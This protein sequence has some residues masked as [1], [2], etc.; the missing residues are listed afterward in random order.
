MILSIR[1]KLANTVRLVRTYRY[2]ERQRKSQCKILDGLGTYDSTLHEAY[3]K[4][5]GLEQKRKSTHCSLV[6]LCICHKLIP[7]N[8]RETC[9][10][11]WTIPI[12]RAWRK[13]LSGATLCVE[14]NCFSICGRE[15]RSLRILHASAGDN[16]IPTASTSAF[17]PLSS[18]RDRRR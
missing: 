7:F 17:R 1:N 15:T 3:R 6:V 8:S 16:V 18:A 11:L 10:N 9:S 2:K 12:A 5:K 13:L 4:A 14:S